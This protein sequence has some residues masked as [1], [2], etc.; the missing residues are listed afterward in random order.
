[1]ALKAAPSAVRLMIKGEDNKLNLNG[2]NLNAT[3][4][5]MYN[6]ATAISSLVDFT[7]E[8]IVR[9]DDSVLIDE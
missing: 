6:F 8:E 2:F 9:Y 1:M 3:D 7:I 5:G 4:E